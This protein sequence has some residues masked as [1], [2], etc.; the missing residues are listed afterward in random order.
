MARTKQTARKSTG[1]KA[2]RKQ[3]ATKA[4][5]KSAPATGGVKKPHR[6][7]PGT[8]ALR[9]IRRYQKSTELL[10]R[11]LPFQRLVREIAQDFKTDL[12]FQ[13]SAVMA[14]QEASEAYLVGLFEDTNLCAIHAKRVTIM[15]KDIQLARRIRG[16]RA[17]REHCHLTKMPPKAS[18]KAVK[19][20]GKAQK[21]ITKSDKKKKRK[22][23][24]SYAIYIY[25]VLKQV[26]PDTGVSSKAM[27]IM[28]SFVNDI[29]ERIAA[30]ASRL[31][32]YNKRSTITSR[33]IQ[34]AVRL[35]LPGEL[36]K[37]AVS[38]GTKAVTKYTSSN[39]LS[40][41]TTSQLDILRHDGDSFGVNG[42]EVGVFKE[43]DEGGKG[44]GKGG[45]KRHRKVLRDNIQGITK[46]AIRRLARRGGVKRISGLIYEE[47][48]G[49][50][51]VFLEN[52][53]RDAV[54]YTEHAKRKT[55]TAMDVVYALKRQGRTLYGFG[56]P[57]GYDH[58]VI[59]LVHSIHFFC[60]GFL[61]VALA[62]GETVFFGLGALG[63]AVGTFVAF[64]AFGLLGLAAA[65]TTLGLAAGFF[66]AGFFGE[67]AFFALGFAASVF[68]TG[69]LTA[70]FV[71]DPSFL[72]ALGLAFGF[73]A[74]VF[75]AA[76]LNDPDAPFPL[77]CTK[78]PA[79]TADF[80]YFLMKTRVLTAVLTI[81]A[82]L[83]CV[84]LGFGFLAFAA[85]FTA[86]AL[87]AGD[88][89]DA[90]T[91]RKHCHLT[92]MPPK[93]SGKA[94]K[95]AGKAQKNITKTDK[96]KKRKR[97]ESYAIYI[98]KVLKQ[99]HPDTGV[100]SKAMSIMNSFVNDIFE[101]I[102]AEASRLAHYNKRSTITSR[103]IQTA[104]RLLLPGELA[105]HA[106][107]EGTKAV[108]KYTSSKYTLTSE[109]VE[110]ATLT[111][112]CVDNVHSCDS[113]PFGVF[114]VGDCITDD[115]LKEYL[116]DTTSFFVDQTRNTFDTT[117]T[118]ETTDGW[119][120]A[121]LSHPPPWENPP[122]T[123]QQIIF[124]P[125]RS[126]PP[127]REIP[128]L[129][130]TGHSMRNIIPSLRTLNVQSS[131]DFDAMARTKQTARK[132]TG[133]KAPRKQLATKAARKSAPATGGVK[134]PHRYR[135][136]TVALREIRRYQ[137]STELLIR[138]L[139]FQRLVREIAQD[140]KT[141]L[142]FQSS[143]VMALQEASEAYLVGLFED[144]NL[145]AIHAKRVTIMPKDIQLARR[146]RGERA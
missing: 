109:S 55:V 98:Y 106:V 14:L 37:H 78:V 107:S 117:S 90:A 132:S 111:F 145:C 84:G 140:F 18:G 92:K 27:S 77:V 88:A 38:E 54:T 133:G 103:E 16:E 75:F 99:V 39:S 121:W 82:V 2:P 52:V 47:T 34:T 17:F 118:S 120:E 86:S 48:R 104:V 113:L 50:L 139:P 144:T 108:T 87:G 102:A 146:I 45:A 25:K 80:R 137:K 116:E 119:F 21:N 28:N 131:R 9:E 23:K 20:A 65:F 125:L 57:F 136:G 26:H 31:A 24:E 112:Q 74:S 101:R 93:A 51:K 122:M 64:L 19:K 53:I 105:K 85:F 141:D 71:D 62:L 124:P 138:K 44:L 115:V 58:G 59:E 30:E 96:K 73:E 89:V 81:S 94:V 63:L 46:P 13:S 36:A 91:V 8:V 7:R 95:K 70:T 15:P 68:F 56:G 12:R 110:S 142:R 83:G 3:L 76:S 60:A 41:N 6:Y 49:V 114:G 35:L 128:L 22:R 143:A 72:A 135:P 43:T 100:S 1:G 33:E 129:Y 97:K 10:I 11:K 61:V 69:F 4:A 67:A 32:H 42:A 29:F 126:F 134:K 5:R 79:V 40:S 66:T 130:N 127:I 123:K